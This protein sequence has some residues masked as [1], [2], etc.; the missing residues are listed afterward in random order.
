MSAVLMLDARI[1]SAP[2][3]F[4]RPLLGI[5]GRE[6]VGNDSTGLN[7]S[8]SRQFRQNPPVYL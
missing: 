4:C 6:N 2:N 3:E 1:C 7:G 8:M 5:N